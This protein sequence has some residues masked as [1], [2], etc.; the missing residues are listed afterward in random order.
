MYSN[1]HWPKTLSKKPN[2]WVL[3]NVPIWL[4]LTFYHWESYQCI[5]SENTYETR[6]FS[7]TRNEKCSILSVLLTNIQ[8]FLLHS[9]CNYYII[10]LIQCFYF[11]SI[12][13]WRFRNWR[14][15]YK[16]CLKKCFIACTF[17]CDFSLYKELGKKMAYTQFIYSFK[18]I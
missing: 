7:S 16:Y 14:F 13:T 6:W 9:I 3:I 17:V 10:C 1:W 2:D 5:F 12:A 11:N 8:I 18:I 15:V 4:I